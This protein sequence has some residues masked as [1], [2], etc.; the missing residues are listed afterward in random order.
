M[1]WAKIAL[2]E[3]LRKT[4]GKEPAA[5]VMPDIDATSVLKFLGCLTVLGDQ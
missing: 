5:L 2:F 3:F 4:T 1:R